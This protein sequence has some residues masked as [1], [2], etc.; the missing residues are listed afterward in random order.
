MSSV[1]ELFPTKQ[2]PLLRDQLVTLA[3][4]EE[5]KKDLLLSI[6]QLLTDN[7]PPVG[8]KWLKSYEV[9]ELLRISSGTL[10][11][12]RSNG[13]LPYTKIGGIIYYNLDDINKLLVDMQKH[14][15]RASM[16]GKS[17]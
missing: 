5:F 2:R 11:T 8:K 6:K 1:R 14:P 16:S 12:L 4:L 10:Q 13:T 3:D 17:I 9:R 7:K 15:S